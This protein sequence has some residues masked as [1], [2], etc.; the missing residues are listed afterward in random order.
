MESTDLLTVRLKKKS[1]FCRG[2]RTLK[3]KKRVYAGDLMVPFQK[4][5]K[6]RMYFLIDQTA[7]IKE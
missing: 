4:R 5:H 6:R 3:N 7:K 2:I 1:L